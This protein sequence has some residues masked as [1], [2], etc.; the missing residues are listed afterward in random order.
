MLYGSGRFC[1]ETC[2]R[3]YA[4]AARRQAIS[5]KVSET[6]RRKYQNGEIAIPNPKGQK[7]PNGTNAGGQKVH[8][9]KLKRL[10]K[11]KNGDVLDISYQELLDYELMHP[12]CEI[13]G[14]K[15]QPKLCVDHDHV[16]KRFRGLLCSQ[17]NRS[18]GWYE[19]NTHSIQEYLAR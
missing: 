15:Y 4:T 5:A 1:S 7:S 12:V 13:C 16:T 11:S 2:A 17:C 6:M 9:Q 19:N 3:S 10:V 18:L 14:K 8:E